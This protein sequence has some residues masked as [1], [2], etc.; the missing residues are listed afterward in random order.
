MYKSFLFRVAVPLVPIA[1]RNAG[2]GPDEGIDLV[3]KKN[4]NTVFVQCKQWR[5]TKVGVNIV[6]EVYGVMTAKKADS[7]IVKAGSGD[8]G[9]T[10]ADP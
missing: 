10:P 6:R 5:S 3:L 1:V 4:G 7:A 9:C 2:A 8:K